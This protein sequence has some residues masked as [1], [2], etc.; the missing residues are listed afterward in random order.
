[1]Q[2]CTNLISYTDTQYESLLILSELP[3]ISCSQICNVTELPIYGLCLSELVNGDLQVNG[4]KICMN[5]FVFNGKQCVCEV[6]YF[7][8][9]AKCYNVQT[10]FD[11]LDQYIYQNNSQL[12][13]E[14]QSNLS[15]LGQQIT[16]NKVDI[17][18]K[19]D[20]STQQLLY[21]ITALNNALIDQIQIVN[22]SIA[23][24]NQNLTNNLQVLNQDLINTKLILS[25][26]LN[27]VNNSLYSLIEQNTIKITD[28]KTQYNNFVNAA[29]LNNSI[30]QTEIQ[31]NNN[32]IQ[33]VTNQLATVNSTLSSGITT[34][35]SDLSNYKTQQDNIIIGINGNI[36]TV[37]NQLA[38]VNS[39]LSSGITTLSSDLSNYKTQQDNII[40]GINGNIQTVNTN[41]S[42][43]Y[44]TL[45]SLQQQIDS[46]IIQNV[47]VK[48]VVNNCGDNRIQVC[49]NGAC[50]VFE[51]QSLDNQSCP[52]QDNSCSP[53]CD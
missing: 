22:V 32:N 24:V 5:P 36:Q 10:Q 41:I 26:Q 29:I 12:N 31:T 44:N 21:D 52:I 28:L 42:N 34:L 1:M 8:S 48:K 39:T 16:N 53:T 6:G 18:N 15:T 43:I 13:N 35:S 4:T 14:L 47:V 50:G 17:E 19:L 49:G 27:T 45:S 11:N 3:S 9:N 33:T 30:Q 2:V 25:S 20:S 37:T 7:L 38:T 46:L 51:T 23:S 40:I